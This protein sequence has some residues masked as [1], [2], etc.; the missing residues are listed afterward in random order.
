MDCEIC[1]GSRWKS[2]TVDGV[3]RMVRCDC[4]RDAVIDQ[5]LAKSGIP[6]KYKRAE[7]ST[8]RQ[9]REAQRRALR[10]AVK[11]VEAFPVVD[12]G[13]LFYGPPGV[14]KTHLAIGILKEAI[15]SKGAK[16][17]FFETMDLLTKV[18]DTYNRSSEETELEV[19]RPVLQSDLLVLDD[20]ASGVNDYTPW[21]KEM[22]A[23]VVNTRYNANK[24]TILTTNLKDTPDSTDRN[25]LIF[26][27]GARTRS[28]L[29]EMCELVEIQDVD[30]REVG[31]DEDAERIEKWKKESPASPENVSKASKKMESLG[32]LLP[33]RSKAQARAKLKDG[34]H[35][36][37]LQWPGGRAGSK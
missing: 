30:F 33:S 32:G 23:L 20:V 37:E 4:W 11:F 31:Q 3:E 10:A 36:Y 18:R 28:R 19:L 8:F 12:R 26:Q 6:A 16:G 22:L 9:T 21:A 27:L 34:P 1:H 7:L 15:R 24:P 29:H 5:V 17:F 35:Q 25:T 13:L 2:V 14:G